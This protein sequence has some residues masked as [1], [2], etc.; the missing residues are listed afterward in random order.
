M[1]APAPPAA[2]ERTKLTPPLLSSETSE[3]DGPQLAAYA[4]AELQALRDGFE[5][6]RNR[7]S[8]LELV[9][10]KALSGP[11]IVSVSRSD[12]GSPDEPQYTPVHTTGP[13]SGAGQ[14]ADDFRSPSGPS[15]VSFAGAARPLQVLTEDTDELE[16]GIALEFMVRKLV[17]AL[18]VSQSD[19]RVG[20]GTRQATPVRRWR[21]SR[22][23]PSPSFAIQRASL[24]F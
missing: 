8:R 23:R 11:Q 2:A 21:R 12:L 16:A 14:G 15:R 3:L 7:I 6:Y 20:T 22:S 9:L 17:L 19:Q 1:Y 10:T 24:S 18:M 5:G 13:N 4:L